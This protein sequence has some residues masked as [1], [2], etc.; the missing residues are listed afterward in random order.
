MARK[1]TGGKGPRAALTA[2]AVAARRCAVWNSHVVKAIRDGNLE[3]LLQLRQD[4]AAG[5]PASMISNPE[6]ADCVQTMGASERCILSLPALAVALGSEAAAIYLIRAAAE[7]AAAKAGAT[8]EE[9]AAAPECSSQDSGS[10]L[11]PE[12]GSA[13][14]S[15]LDESSEPEEEFEPSWFWASAGVLLPFPSG[16]EGEQCQPEDSYGPEEVLGE[17]WLKWQGEVRLGRQHWVCVTV[18]QGARV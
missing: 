16:L 11:E 12:E 13:S 9:S 7:D 8:E 14:A 6:V 2:A 4:A 3:L 17:A 18:W 1:A 10:E 15:E 5:K